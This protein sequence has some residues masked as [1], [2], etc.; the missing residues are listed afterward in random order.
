MRA[1]GRSL[2]IGHRFTPSLHSTPARCYSNAS[3]PSQL[4]AT[5]LDARGS[6]SFTQ[7][8]FSEHLSS[9]SHHLHQLASPDETNRSLLIHVGPDG[10]P[11]IALFPPTLAVPPTGGAARGNGPGQ[12]QPEPVLLTGNFSSLRAVLMENSLGAAIFAS[13]EDVTR[14]TG[15]AGPLLM[16]IMAASSGGSSCLPF[17]LTCGDVL[18]IE[19]HGFFWSYG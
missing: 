18:G 16:T 17:V 14:V 4:L 19:Q 6:E 15:I 11:Y 5:P 10:F 8:A 13:R 7:Q 1:C 12:Q 2:G 3:A 9:P